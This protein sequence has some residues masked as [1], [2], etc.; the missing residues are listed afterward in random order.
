MRGPNG[1]I[2]P[3][4]VVGNAVHCCRVLVGDSEET[5]AGP[6][7]N[8]GLARAEALTPERRSEIA[9]N[10]AAKRWKNV[11]GGGQAA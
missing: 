11:Q 7:R 10:A 3:G 5:Y 6:Q 9:K 2:R 8:G 4:D 1:E